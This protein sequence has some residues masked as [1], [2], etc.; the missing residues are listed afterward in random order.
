M[1]SKLACFDRHGM[2]E[3]QDGL[4]AEVLPSDL[5]SDPRG[6]ISGGWRNNGCSNPAGCDVDVPCTNVMCREVNLIC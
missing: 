3:V 4:L 5:S 2:F 6:E 1:K